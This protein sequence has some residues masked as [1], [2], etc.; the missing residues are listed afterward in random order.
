MNKAGYRVLL[1]DDEEDLL[2]L[3]KVRLESDGYEV[4]TA[5]SGEEALAKFSVSNPH[6]VLTD[7][8]MTG[9]RCLRRFVSG[10]RRYR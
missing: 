9:W 5:L 8:R 10:T 3:W 2:K 6:V 1:V 4:I 7:L